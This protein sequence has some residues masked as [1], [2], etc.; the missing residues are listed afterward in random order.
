MFNVDGIVVVEGK[1]DKTALSRVISA[2]IFVLNG[3]TGANQKKIDYLKDLSNNNTI[4]LLTDPDFAGEKIREKINKNIPNIINLYA[5]RNLCLRDGNVG[6]ENLLDEAILN[7]FKN[8]RHSKNQKDKFSMQDLIDN[9][10]TLTDDSSI[11]RAVLGDVLSIGYSNTKGLLKKLNL[12]NI[13][14]EEFEN[15]MTI[16]NK[17]YDKKDKIACIFG[18]FFPVHKGHISFIKYV[19]RYCKKLYVYVC[20]ETKRDIKLQEESKLNKNMTIK[21]RKLFVEKEL[22]GYKNIYV[23]VL[24]EDGIESYPNGWQKWSERVRQTL[25]KDNIKIDCIFTNEVQDIE[26]YSKYLNTPAYLVDPKRIGYYISSTKIRENP[27]K[28]I[29]FIPDSVKEFL[30]L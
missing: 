15:A 30:G 17:M 19:S 5:S 10:L 1:D 28:Y 27:E 23:K 29:D 18:K 12:L 20:E 14:K 16:V 25:D 26:N 21:D 6:V 9:G 24:N 4:Y 13:S 3:M 8:I 22:K 2:N 7:I 11:K